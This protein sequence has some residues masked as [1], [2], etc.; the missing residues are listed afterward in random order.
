MIKKLN[1]SSKMF[2]YCIY[3]YTLNHKFNLKLPL[4]IAS[5]MDLVSY[6]ILKKRKPSRANFN[7]L[8]KTD[9]IQNIKKH[10]SEV[11]QNRN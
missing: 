5:M 6:K 11:L 8:L 1:D 4:F 9:F 10:T 3:I 2:I 7:T